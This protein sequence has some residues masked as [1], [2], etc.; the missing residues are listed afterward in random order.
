VISSR[1]K[2]AVQWEPGGVA[3]PLHRTIGLCTSLRR[4]DLRGPCQ[5][6]R[7]ISSLAVICR[8]A[9]RPWKLIPSA[10]HHPHL[11]RL[12][13]SSMVELLTF[14]GKRLLPRLCTY[15]RT[16]EYRGKKKVLGRIAGQIVSMIYALL[17]T[18]QE[19]LSRVPPGELPHPMLY[20]LMPMYTWLSQLSGEK[21]E[22]SWQW[23]DDR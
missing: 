22:N 6:R 23:L 14:R 12:F 13:N 10:H 4:R 18:D 15:D 16:R 11:E 5:N 20:V 2:Q 7:N 17:K 3:R 9:W 1:N 21:R 8:N 19:T